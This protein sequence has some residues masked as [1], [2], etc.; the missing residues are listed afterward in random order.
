MRRIFSNGPAKDFVL[1]PVT[2]LIRKS[3]RFHIAAPFVTKTDFLA[4]AARAGKSIELLVGLNEATSPQALAAVHG[5]PSISIRYLTRRFHAKIYIFDGAAM[6]GSSNLTDGGLLSNR[7][8]TM[9]LDQSSDSDAIDEL[10]ALFVELWD[11]A[12]VLTSDKLKEF[13]IVH[14]SLKRPGPDADTVIENAVGKAEPVNINVTSGNR[15]SERNFLEELRRQVYEQYKPA[16]AEVT[17]LLAENKLRRAEL[18]DIGEA[19][20]TNRFLN[21]VRRTHVPGDEGWQTAPLRSQA[22]RR[23]E[24]LSLGREWATTYN[25][26]VPEDFADWLLQVQ[27]TFGSEAVIAAAP[28]EEITEGLLSVHAFLEQ[29]RFVKGGTSQLP[30]AFWQAN[31][32]DVAK[33]KRTL[34]YLVHGPGDFIKRL[35]DI[36]YNPAMKLGYFGLFCALE[37]FG[38]IKPDECPPMN[39]RMAKALRFLGFDVRGS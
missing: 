21:F 35:H 15:T 30:I 24:I 9:C 36:L 2:G 29:L 28:K 33:V 38:T 31:N 17:A 10:R 25:S 26:Q 11:A 34:S 8:A 3:R 6:L 27:R 23:E 16:F 22:E 18:E 20:E 12:L 39:G 13:A 32:Q 19:N 5:I 7:E 14:A 37:L 4:E 1:N